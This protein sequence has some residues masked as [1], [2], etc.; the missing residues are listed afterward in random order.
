MKKLIALILAISSVFFLFSC[1]C[2]GD[3]EVDEPAGQTLLYTE[4]TINELRSTINRQPLKYNDTEIQ[5]E[6][7]ALGSTLNSFY[8]CFPI[9]TTKVDLTKNGVMEQYAKKEALEN[10][11]ANDNAILVEYDLTEDTVRVLDGDYVVV[12]A[13]LTVEIVDSKEIKI[14][15]LDVVCEIKETPDI[16]K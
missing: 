5:L 9:P 12:T 8:L 3:D 11:K 15:L 13:T 1:S 14:D 4:T 6:G 7:Y 16:S 10:A 2:G